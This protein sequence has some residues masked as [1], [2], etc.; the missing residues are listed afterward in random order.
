MFWADIDK[1]SCLSQQLN[2][3]A[4]ST[5]RIVW[6]HMKL[7]PYWTQMQQ[8]LCEADISRKSD[9]CGDFKMYLK[10]NQDYPK[11]FGLVKRA[12]FLWM[13]T[14]TSKICMCGTVN[15][16]IKTMEAILYPEKNAQCGVLGQ[17]VVLWASSFWWYYDCWW[18]SPCLP[19]ISSI[20]LFGETF[21]LQDRTWPHTGNTVLAVL[22]DHSDDRAFCNNFP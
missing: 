17:Q 2:L 18:L 12:V 3:E 5:C 13:A 1:E 11:T 10:D 20:S 19:R 7:F 9:F 21:F 6:E 8:A 15:T 14:W 16:C 4:S 22:N